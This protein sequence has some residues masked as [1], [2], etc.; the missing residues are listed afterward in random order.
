MNS[1]NQVDAAAKHSS[2]RAPAL[3]Y[4]VLP[5][6][7]LFKRRK[8]NIAKRTWKLI[9]CSYC[10]VAL[11]LSSLYFCW[12]YVW[13]CWVVLGLC[14]VSL[15]CLWPILGLCCLPRVASGLRLLY[16]RFT[17]DRLGPILAHLGTMLGVA[18]VNVAPSWLSVGLSWGH[19]GTMLGPC[20]VL[21]GRLGPMLAHL[22]T[23][24]GV[25]GFYV[26]TSW[27]CVGLSWGHV[28]PSWDYVERRKDI[29]VQRSQF[30]TVFA[31]FF[32][33]STF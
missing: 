3:I 17:L 9:C 15:G 30:F 26:G 27:L 2:N 7:P 20:W 29:K 21:L 6:S 1:F 14:W 31:V 23:M 19:P 12:D 4:T 10:W 16:F 33:H 24:L 28:A 11:G 8:T 13:F 32:T 25:P 22:G 18:E 5:H